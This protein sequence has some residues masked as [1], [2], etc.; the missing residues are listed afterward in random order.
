MNVTELFKMSA[1]IFLSDE[2]AVKMNLKL[3]FRTAA[4]KAM[5]LHLY[6]IAGRATESIL[7]G[8]T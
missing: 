7:A 8:Q 3:H 2:T 5:N 4:K 1:T 6:L